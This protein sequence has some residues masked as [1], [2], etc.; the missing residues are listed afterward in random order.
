VKIFV[1]GSLRYGARA[2]DLMRGCKRIGLDKIDGAIYNLGSFPGYKPSGPGEVIGDVY[3]VPLES[4]ESVLQ[5]LDRYEGY[6]ASDES[7]S[8][9]VRFKI[10]TALG[11]DC[12]VYVYKHGIANA[13]FIPS[14]DWIEYESS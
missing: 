5:R 8:L 10:Q 3:E 14:G 12:W 7:Q 2:N 4:S 11:R 6:H 13:E 1:Y 9:Y